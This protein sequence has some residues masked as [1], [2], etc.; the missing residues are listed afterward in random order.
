[1][2]LDFTW[3][4]TN[5]S[6]LCTPVPNLGVAAPSSLPPPGSGS[7]RNPSQGVVDFVGDVKSEEGDSEDDNDLYH[8][9]GKQ[10]INLKHGLCRT[11]ADYLLWGKVD[12]ERWLEGRTGGENTSKSG[13]SLKL[14]S[15]M[16]Y[17]RTERER[18]RTPVFFWWLVERWEG[19]TPEVHKVERLVKC[20]EPW[21]TMKDYYRTGKCG[22]L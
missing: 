2:V 12:R 3:D 10:T 14:P 18:H 1:M 21:I 7:Q 19:Q 15:E 8:A 17:N 4:L 16:A 6:P 5:P 11:K 20:S 9:Q 22:K 13:A